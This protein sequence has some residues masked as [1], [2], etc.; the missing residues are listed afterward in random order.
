MGG[1]K[2]TNNCIKTQE[3]QFVIIFY[4]YYYYNTVV[5]VSSGFKMSCAKTQNDIYDIYKFIMYT[6]C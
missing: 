3:L 5:Q 1:G 6:F 2:V 4:Y